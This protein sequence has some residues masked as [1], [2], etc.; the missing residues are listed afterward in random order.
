M[1]WNATLV[2]SIKTSC[3]VLSTWFLPEHLCILLPFKLCHLYLFLSRRWNKQTVTKDTQSQIY[4]PSET[5][6]KPRSHT[7]KLAVADSW[8]PRQCCWENRGISFTSAP[9][10]ALSTPS[11]LVQFFNSFTSFL[12]ANCAELPLMVRER[13]KRSW[14]MFYPPT[15]SHA[16]PCGGTLPET[17]TS[18]QHYSIAVLWAAVATTWEIHFAWIWFWATSWKS[19]LTPV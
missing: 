4:P 10:K 1:E 14:G 8:F 12:S 9:Q 11:L 7:F 17:G 16:L 18:A 19:C 2:I 5:T 6:Y 3:C 15:Q 13:V